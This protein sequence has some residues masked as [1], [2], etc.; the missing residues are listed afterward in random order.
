MKEIL[1]SPNQSKK[2]AELYQTMEE[3]YGAVAAKIGMTCA[4]C[5][6]NCCDSY[7]LHYTYAEWAYL[8]EGLRTLDPA[9]LALI[10]DRSQDYQAE[11]RHL[12]NHGERPQLMCPLNEEG[13]CALYSHR[14]MIC[15]LHGI[16]AAMTR[17]DGKSLLFPG[18]FRC[19]E[20]VRAKY[21]VEDDAP[22]MDRTGLLARVAAL[23]SELLGGRRHLYP[24]VKRTIAEMIAG[25]PPR[26]DKPFC[27]R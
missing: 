6:D 12:L 23:E 11:S 7:F 19:Q 27:E 9:L 3:Q 24:K 16:P 25:G 21:E 2:L 13:R 26:I 4:G 20:Q 8:W 17:P 18:C 14:L 10:I 15:R 22:R 1:L 5:P